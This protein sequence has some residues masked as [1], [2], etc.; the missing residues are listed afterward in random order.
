MYALTIILIITI[1]VLLTQKRNEIKKEEEEEKIQEDIIFESD[2]AIDLLRSENGQIERMDL[3]YYLLC[4]VASEIPFWYDY[5][6]IKAQTI[7]ARTYMY[8][9]IQNKLEQV[10]DI[11]DSHL[12]CQAF[13]DLEK[14]EEIWRSK[15]YTQK[16]IEEG[17]RKIKKAI[18]ESTGMIITYKGEIINA[19]FHASS[20]QK[21]ENARAIWANEDIPYLKS[22]ENIENEDYENRE[23]IVRK[24]YTEFKDILINTGY[25]NGLNKDEFYN[26]KINEYTES[27]RVKN[28]NV[29]QKYI[30]A[31]TLRTLFG[32]K[33]T[34]FTISLDE[35]NIIFNVIGYGHGVGM[36]QVGADTYAK[37]GKSYDEIIKY[38]Y[39]DVNIVNIQDIQKK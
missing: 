33:S 21:T 9:K 23:S 1:I 19:L 24:S 29:G 34:N 6:A 4:V 14:L 20:P 10:G 11:C 15:G 28:I 13:N 16:E 5:E 2:I 36:S 18:M 12:H 39:T 22:V 3:N 31:E 7:V 25:I 26:I 17:E 32:L 27:G 30:K 37:E 38:Y 35:E 8:N